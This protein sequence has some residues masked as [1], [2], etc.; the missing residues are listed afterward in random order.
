MRLLFTKKFVRDYRKLPADVQK[1]VDKQ[2]EFLLTDPKHPSL[3]LKKMHDP[4][5]IWEAE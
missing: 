5:S 4:R 1:A 2:L 3:S